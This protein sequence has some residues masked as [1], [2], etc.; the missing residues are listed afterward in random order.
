[1]I[2]CK[3]KKSLSLGDVPKVQFMYL[4]THC[5]MFIIFS[6]SLALA[7]CYIANVLEIKLNLSIES[8]SYIP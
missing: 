7:T 8:I 3:I 1:M 4:L 6:F 2:K 5:E